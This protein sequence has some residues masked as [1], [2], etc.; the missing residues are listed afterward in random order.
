M[1]NL[2]ED[3]ISLLNQLYKDAS[4]AINDYKK[5]YK[6]ARTVR[7]GEG[8]EIIKQVDVREWYMQKNVNQT[9]WHDKGHNNSWVADMP[10]DEYQMDTAYMKFLGQWQ[11]TFP[12]AIV[13]IDVFS[14]LANVAAVANLEADNTVVR[15]VKGMFDRMGGSPTYVYTDKGQ[16]FSSNKFKQLMANEGT[17]IEYTVRHALF[18]ERF[19]RTLKKYMYKK[20]PEVEQ[21]WYKLLDGFLDDYNKG[22][23]VNSTTMAPEEAKE[24]ENSAVVRANLVVRAQKNRKYPSLKVGDSVRYYVKPDGLTGKKESTSKWSDETYQIE[25][26]EYH[27]GF[28]H[29]KLEGKDGSYQR[30]ELQKV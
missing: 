7:Q 12:Y 8:G 16:E 4:K 22:E 26:I 6:E 27:L 1:G 20:C 3:D 17:E 25:S 11:G 10:R 15:A 21:P 18:A 24:D 23:R 30:H 5:L 28:K 19:I 9:K 2:T 13:C 29:F 14:K